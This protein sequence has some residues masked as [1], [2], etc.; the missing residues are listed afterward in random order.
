MLRQTPLIVNSSF[1]LSARK[2]E[3]QDLVGEL[4]MCVRLIQEGCTLWEKP[5][6]A[7][8][9]SVLYHEHRERGGQG[10]VSYL[11]FLQSKVRGVPEPP[12]WVAAY[13]EN[14]K[15]FL[16]CVGWVRYLK[17]RGLK[18]RD[19]AD[20]LGYQNLHAAIQRSNSETMTGIF[21]RLEKFLKLRKAGVQRTY[22]EFDPP[23]LPRLVPEAT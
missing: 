1:A 16:S 13:I 23:G 7:A 17:A 20:L 9:G 5:S 8:Y 6:L 4:V 22:A 14:H 21:E 11:K 3:D 12:D 10:N 2:L 18:D 19:V 15:R